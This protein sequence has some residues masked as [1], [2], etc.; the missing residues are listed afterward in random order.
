MARAPAG[1]WFNMVGTTSPEAGFD[2]G[3]Y[4][5][6]SSR[7]Q[8][9]V[10]M[11]G[12]ADMTTDFSPTFVRLKPTVI[13]DFDLTAASPITYVSSDDPPFLILQGDMDRIVPLAQSQLLYQRLLEAGVPVELVVAVNG[14]HGFQTSNMQPTR[15]ELTEMIVDFFLTHLGS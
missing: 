9:V 8:A 10:D 11:Y 2:V 6:Q 13:P 14:D 5:E 7:V 15:S 1:T 4:L 3:E 12:P